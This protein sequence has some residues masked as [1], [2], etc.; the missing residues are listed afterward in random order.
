MWK[1]WT[2]EKKRGDKTKKKWWKN[3]ENRNVERIKEAKGFKMAGHR[4]CS[5]D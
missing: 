1:R 3:N 2:Q 4:R 5:T